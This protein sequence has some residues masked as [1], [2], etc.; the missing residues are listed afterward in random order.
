MTW[1]HRI[2][3]FLLVFLSVGV[4]LFSMRY[5]SFE[6]MDLLTLKSDEIWNLPAYKVAFYSHVIL[7][8]IA[9]LI[10]PFQ[11][12]DSIR[13]KHPAWHRISGKIYTGC[14]WL[15]GLAG[16]AAAQWTLGGTWAI[17]GFSFLAAGW[18]FTT[19]KAYVAIR[20]KKIQWHRRWM[21]R[22]FALTLAA[23]TLRLYLPAL[24]GLLGFSFE[25]AYRIVSWLCWI[26][27][28]LVAEILLGS[29]TRLT[30]KKAFE[31]EK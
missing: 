10:G 6:R 1:T 27:N 4:A 3:S 22:S 11:F 17:L 5:W 24:Q 26:P 9:L 28:L 23:V 18:I 30:P 29:F 20:Q 21:I 8:P 15:G 2:A 19:A 13:L 7:S 31:T 25:E 16:L 14:C 12:L